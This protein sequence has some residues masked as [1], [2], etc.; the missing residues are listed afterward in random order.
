M[1]TIF[2]RLPPQLFAC[3]NKAAVQHG[4]ELIELDKQGLMPLKH[5][6]LF[7]SAMWLLDLVETSIRWIDNAA[8]K[9]QGTNKIQFNTKYLHC[10]FTHHQKCK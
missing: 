10:K 7:N 9:R 1:S 4:I 3:W 2:L 5:F 6:I 8:Q